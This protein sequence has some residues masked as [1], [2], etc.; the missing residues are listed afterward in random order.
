MPEETAA[1]EAPE[2]GIGVWVYVIG[3][4]V[5]FHLLALVQI[6]PILAHYLVLFSR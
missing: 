5:L 6:N 1:V 2:E 3:G 4:L